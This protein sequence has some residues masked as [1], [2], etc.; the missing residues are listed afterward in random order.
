M[1]KEKASEEEEGRVLSQS[2]PPGS[3][4]EENTGVELIVS[5]SP[6][7]FEKAPLSPQKWVLTSVE[8]PLGFGKKKVRVVVFDEEGKKTINY[9]MYSP[10]ERIW[11]SSQVVGEGE[12]RVYLEDKLI[13]L[14]RIGE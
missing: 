14:K 9:G 6:D 4:V 13:K 7:K 2:P 1:I 8:I 11:I 12:I 3:M 5:A 10:G